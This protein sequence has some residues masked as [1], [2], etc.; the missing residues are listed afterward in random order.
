MVNGR[1]SDLVDYVY[2]WFYTALIKSDKAD[3]KKTCF[4]QPISVKYLQP[5]QILAPFLSF[6]QHFD[7]ELTFDV[8]FGS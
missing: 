5:L 6:K 7:S 3:L 4:L 2:D 1:T 8:W